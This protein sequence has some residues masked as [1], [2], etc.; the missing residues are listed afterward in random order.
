VSEERLT[1]RETIEPH[2]AAHHYRVK[3]PLEDAKA[4][5]RSP[6]PDPPGPPGRAP[7]D[8]DGDLRR[9]SSRRQSMR[10]C[11]TFSHRPDDHEAPRPS[12]TGQ[13]QG[14]AQKAAS[15]FPSPKATGTI[16]GPLLVLSPSLRTLWVG[17]RWPSCAAGAVRTSCSWAILKL[18]HASI[19]AGGDACIGRVNGPSATAI[20][21]STPCDHPCFSS[22]GSSKDS[23]ALRFR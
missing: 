6:T 23:I 10:R 7:L 3:F 16:G 17:H 15:G 2:P 8:F 19:N 5:L 4:R 11:R 13:L 9:T 1:G 22:A 21:G 12:L 14:S 20:N 18:M